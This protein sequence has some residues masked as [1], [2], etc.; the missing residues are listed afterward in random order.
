MKH[1]LFC[2]LSVGLSACGTVDSRFEARQD[3]LSNADITTNGRVIQAANLPLY[4]HPIR[5]SGHRTATIYIEGDGY[6]YVSRSK[7]SSNPTPKTP[8]GLHLALADSDST[9]IYYAA[10]PCQYIDDDRF[11]TQCDVKYWTTHRYGLAVV[12][13]FHHLLDAIKSESI[14]KSFD[15]VGF[16]GGGNVAGLLAAERSDIRSIRTVAG[17]LDNDFFTA[18]HKVSDMPYSL[19]MADAA[20][21]LADIPQIHFVAE[22]DRLVP[23]VISASYARQLPHQACTDIRIVED[24]SHL[25]GWAEQWPEL[26]AIKPSCQ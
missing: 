8:V 23:P 22:R 10:R 13:S 6:A 4:Y 20:G 2:L 1:L 12:Q 17:N 7:P 18:Y 14:V 9:N 21:K 15:L 24:T 16:S 19:N 5:T 26:L 11:Q 25:K 3:S